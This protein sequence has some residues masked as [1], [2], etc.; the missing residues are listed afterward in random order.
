MRT[1]DALPHVYAELDELCVSKLDEPDSLR[2]TWVGEFELLDVRQQ[3]ALTEQPSSG[4]AKPAVP[5]NPLNVGVDTM[6][7]Q[8]KSPYQ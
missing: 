8:T 2:Q 7:A 1:A 3:G 6:C 5:K 4:R